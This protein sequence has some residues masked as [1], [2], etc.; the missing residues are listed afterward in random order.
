MGGFR[1][2][3]AREKNVGFIV[4]RWYFKP[5]DLMRSLREEELRENRESEIESC[6]LGKMQNTAKEAEKEG[7]V[8]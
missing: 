7:S 5:R 6:G 2:E 3:E 8:K 1:I 4:H